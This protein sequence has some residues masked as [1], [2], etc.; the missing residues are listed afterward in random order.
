MEIRLI[1]IGKEF[2]NYRYEIFPQDLKRLDK[3]YA[4]EKIRCDFRLRIEGEILLFRGGY[5][6]TFAAPCD[7]CLTSSLFDLKREFELDLIPEESQSEPQNDVEIQLNSRNTD[8]YRGSE[9]DAT[10]YFEDQILLDLPISVICADSCR[11]IC[12]QCGANRNVSDCTCGKTAVNSPF[13]ILGELD[14]HSG[15]K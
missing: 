2:S 1:D 6:T 8:Y 13:A 15:N 4:F 10:R 5:E 3:R 11:G 9:I 14:L 12:T 7:Y